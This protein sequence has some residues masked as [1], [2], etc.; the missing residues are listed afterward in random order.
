MT[1]IKKVMDKA[2]AHLDDTDV[3]EW[4]A[5][6]W[7]FLKDLYKIQLERDDKKP[8]NSEFDDLDDDELEEAEKKL[9]T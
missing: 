9:L 2:L 6:Y 8:N 4:D 1:D 5:Q 7:S 3:D